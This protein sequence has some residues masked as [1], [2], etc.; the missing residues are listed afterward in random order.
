MTKAGTARQ[1]RDKHGMGM[2][3]LKL[4]R[5]MYNENNLLFKNVEECRMYLR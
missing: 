5:I 2:P 3:T 4:S 1:Y